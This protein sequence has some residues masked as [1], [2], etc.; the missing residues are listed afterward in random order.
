MWLSDEVADTITCDHW[1]SG[2]Q[3]MADISQC[4]WHLVVKNDNL[5]IATD[6]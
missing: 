4:Y 5:Y 2:D 1:T 3:A 6:I